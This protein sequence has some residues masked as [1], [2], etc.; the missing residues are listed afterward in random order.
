MNRDGFSDFIRRHKWCV[1]CVSLGLL[2][3]ILVFTIN[4]WRTLLLF[5]ITGLCFLFGT[6]L[7]KGGLDGVKDFFEKLLPRIK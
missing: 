5:A 4:F 3:T 7:D 6:L 1:I 2:F